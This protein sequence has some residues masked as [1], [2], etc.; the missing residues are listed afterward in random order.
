VASAAFGCGGV[1]GP[2]A[3]RLIPGGGVGDGAISGTL[4]VHVTDEETRSAISSAN[5]RVGDSSDPTACNVLTDST[6]LAKFQPESCAGLSGPQTVTI[7]ATGYAPVTWVGVNGSNLTIP[8]RNS[9]PPA[10][11]HATVSGTIAGWASLPVPQMNHQTL[12]LIGYS[13]SKDLGDRANELPQGMRNITVGTQVFPV[14]GNLCVINEAVSNCDWILT[15][16]TGP[17]AL[18]AIIV[19]QFNNN[20]PDTD[21]DDTFTVTGYAFKT[22]FNFTK[23]QVMN[24]VTLDRIADADMQTFTASF[25]SLPSGMDYMGAFPAL[26]LGEE[27]RIAFTLPALDMARTSTRVPRLS[28]PLAGARYS[29]IAQAQDSETQD[30]PST[31]AWMHDV[32]IASTVALSSWLPP[33]SNISVAGGTYAFSAVSGA[34][35][36]GAE[37]VDITGKRIWSITV[38]DATTSFTLPGLAPDP[39]PVGMLTFQ[40]SALLIPGVDVKNFEL[41]VARDRIAGIAHDYVTFT[42]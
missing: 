32:D 2:P 10:P 13:G 26:E 15:T 38:F 3:P 28:G 24:G 11:D 9:N 36:H 14:P 19:D 31:L 6:G 27:G 17:Q 4:Y 16:R 5:V 18:L 25:A 41:D 20:T 37:I 8:I 40:A 35:V 21:A 7:T 29:L 34:T 33:P 39:L 1:S 42:H 12:A 30:R 22:G 23:D